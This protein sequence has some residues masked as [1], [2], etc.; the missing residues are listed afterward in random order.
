MASGIGRTAEHEASGD[1]EG[2]EVRRMTKGSN[3]KILVAM[4][5]RGTPVLSPNTMVKT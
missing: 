2:E 5:L 3:I 4:R 1:A